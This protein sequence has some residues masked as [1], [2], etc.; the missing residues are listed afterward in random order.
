MLCESLILLL[1]EEGVVRRDVA[2][3][4]VESAVDVGQEIAGADGSVVVSMASIGLLRGIASSLSALPQPPAADTAR[5]SA[6]T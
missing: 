4:A 1:V 6:T 2:I 3:G 5:G